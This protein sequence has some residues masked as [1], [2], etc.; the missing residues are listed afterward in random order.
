MPITHG[1]RASQ[2]GEALTNASPF[3]SPYQEF[4]YKSR[5]SRWLEEEGRRENWNET[6][7]RY[8]DFME[9]HLNEKYDYSM[10]GELQEELYNAIYN[11]E[12]MPSMRSDDRR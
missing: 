3:G 11:L 4:I 5:Y 8:L 9:D 10:S 2:R 1:T 7:H 12:V 6:V